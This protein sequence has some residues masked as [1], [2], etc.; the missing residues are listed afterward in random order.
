MLRTRLRLPWGRYSALGRSQKTMPMDR[1]VNST[2]VTTL[3]N[4][5]AKQILEKAIIIFTK[6]GPTTDLCSQ[7]SVFFSLLL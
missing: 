3:V 1:V 7:F 2:M 5:L 4:T 6:N